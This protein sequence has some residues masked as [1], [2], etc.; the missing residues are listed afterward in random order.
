M[1]KRVWVA[2][3][4]TTV[5]GKEDQNET[6]VWSACFAEL[7]SEKDPTIFG[8][9]ATFLNYFIA[10]PGSHD[11]YFHNLKF[12][13]SFILDYLMR[14]PK[15]KCGLYQT[16]ST[17][18][19]KSPNDLLQNEYIYSI[20]DKG[21]WYTLT[22]GKRKSRI[23]FKDSVK[24]LPF[25]L[26]QIASSF[27]TKHS[28]LEME[29][30]GDRHANCP[31]TE[32]E[33]AYIKN[34]VY[35]LKEALEIMFQDGHDKLTIGACALHEFKS[36]FDRNDYKNFF[37]N[38]YHVPI[39]SD[40]Y[41][42]DN[43]ADYIRRS[44]KGAWTYLNPEKAGKKVYHGRTYDTNSLYPYVMHSESGNKYPVGLPCFWSGNYI[45][46]KARESNKL[47][48]I[49]F[50]CAFYLKPRKLPTVQIK[51]NFRY[52]GT[53]FLATS[54]LKIGGKYYNH[55][56][57]ED[58]SVEQVTVTLTMTSADY[59][60]FLEHY[61]VK[62]FEILDGCW[63][64]AESGLFDDYIDTY[65]TQKETSKGAK[66]TEAKL[67]LNNLYGKMSSS[68]SS[69]FKWAYM[70][71]EDIK[72]KVQQEN[73]KEPGYIPIGSF[74]TSYA[75][76]YTIRHA[77][78]NYEHFVYADTDSLHLENIY[79][80]NDVVD[81]EEHKSKFGAWKCETGWREGLFIRSKTY[82]EFIIEENKTPCV[83]HYNLI[84]AGLPDRC[85][86]LFLYSIER[87]WS[88][89]YYRKLPKEGREFLEKIRV[90]E[91]FQYG[92]V[93]P[94]KLMP[95]RVKGGIVLKNTTFHLRK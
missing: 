83:P 82:I 24:L 68:D 22:I 39:S 55:V 12:D 18:H 13:G 6:E 86:E 15:Y 35:V 76:C 26:A 51:G 53:E 23:T 1:K 50:R 30:T 79:S 65:R 58:G 62:Y 21:R 37:P 14:S 61:N 7:F 4:E 94:L 59:E 45:P 73:E 16:G 48:F 72:F 85:K 64:Y 90:I 38:L 93:I 70:D 49:R 3:F 42:Y 46:D 43:A 27:H 66:R 5:T 88:E 84:C 44:Y 25:S 36:R 28:K 74:V 67:F 33:K 77:Q 47:F 60:L 92:L 29:Y 52:L 89:D 56:R 2:D 31:I 57:H 9:I 11:V 8:D 40:L 87:N 69:S 10:L 80:D 34:D 78:K 32:D 41:F 91:D 20:S 17:Y 19:M 81:I 54:D 71:G 75:R 63:F 95:V